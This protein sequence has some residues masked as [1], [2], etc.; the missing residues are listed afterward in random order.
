M[1]ADERPRLAQAGFDIRAPV[2]VRVMHGCL[3]DNVN[4]LSHI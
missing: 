1:A 3:V 4:Y 2:R